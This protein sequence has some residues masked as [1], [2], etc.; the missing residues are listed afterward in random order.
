[1]P[2]RARPLS[3]R[4]FRS[5]IIYLTSN[6]FNKLIPIIIIF[7]ISHKLP[8]SDYGKLS[9]FLTLSAF[10]L[11]ILSFNAFMALDK[12]IPLK[13]IDSENSHQEIASIR[14]LVL[15]L[16]T[17]LFLTLAFLLLLDLWEVTIPLTAAIYSLPFSLVF[18]SL[19]IFKNI[20]APVQYAFNALSCNVITLTIICGLLSI[21]LI[22]PET[23]FSLDK[24]ILAY[25]AGAFIA[26]A[27]AWVN[28]PYIRKGPFALST[29][30]A[31][32]T[33]CA[34]TPFL[35]HGV[36]AVAIN[37][38]DRLLVNHFL[39]AE[40]L[41]RYSVA[42]SIGMSASLLQDSFHKMYAPYV[43]RQYGNTEGNR[44]NRSIEIRNILFG[45]GALIALSSAVTYFGSTI[46]NII[47]PSNYSIEP[48]MA[49]T[50]GLA[51]AVNGILRFFI[52]RLMFMSRMRVS[53]TLL[54]INAGI[55]ILLNL[56]LIPLFGIWGAAITTLTSFSISSIAM[57]IYWHR[58]YY[59]ND[60]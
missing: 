37:F 17:L 34:S 56:M 41:G 40:A 33:A 35:V 18:L 44:F 29:R 43:M 50:I 46:A 10:Y 27:I 24:V 60:D 8:L 6:A 57:F 1:M 48:M 45:G 31:W 21:E 47:L 30:S 25:V 28:N 38:S 49:V 42:Y 12:C 36:S 26:A 2:P 53:A 51:Y 7:L 5:A 3:V 58:N 4:H 32:L 20:E 52:P 15:L 39:D 16:H 55:G 22:F 54:M 13:G 11:P 9:L 59:Q 23:T 19:Q 14:N